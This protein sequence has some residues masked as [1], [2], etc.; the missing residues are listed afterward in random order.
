[1]VLMLQLDDYRASEEG[2]LG[3]M[4]HRGCDIRATGLVPDDAW[5]LEYDW[6]V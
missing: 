6:K 4:G 1:M 3:E 5:K 2:V